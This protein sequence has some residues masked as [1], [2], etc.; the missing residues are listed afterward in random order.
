MQTLEL[1]HTSLSAAQI[2]Q[3]TRS[4]INEVPPSARSHQSQYLMRLVPWAQTGP[5]VWRILKYNWF[6]GTITIL[7]LI[8]QGL[9]KY[10]LKSLSDQSSCSITGQQMSS[11]QPIWSIPLPSHYNVLLLATRR[12]ALGQTAT[13]GRSDG[14]GQGDAIHLDDSNL[15]VFGWRD[16]VMNILPTVSKDYKN[17]AALRKFAACALAWTWLLLSPREQSS[18]HVL[19]TVASDMPYLHVE[20]RHFVVPYNALPKRFLHSAVQRVLMN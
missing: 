14:S 16:A 13:M 11:K 1:Q 7:T 12:T 10:L 15:T 18:V 20:S 19:H 2:N 6:V 3:A 9:G 8:S 4:S 5:V 17:F